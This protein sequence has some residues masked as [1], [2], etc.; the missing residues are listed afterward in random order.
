MNTTSVERKVQACPLSESHNIRRLLL[1]LAAAMPDGSQMITIRENSPI[2]TGDVSSP[3]LR[4][5]TPG[6]S[7][8]PR[9]FKGKIGLIFIIPPLEP[10]VARRVV[11]SWQKHLDQ[12]AM[13]VIPTVTQEARTL[14]DDLT[15]E[16]GNFIMERKIDDIAIMS[17]DPCTHYWI[18]NNGE[19]GTCKNCGRERNF[20]G[21]EKDTTQPWACKISVTIT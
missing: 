6:Q 11:W 3:L 12:R 18:I 15:G 7:V 10:V 17:P 5:F 14:M 16:Y 21:L 19:R 1:S 9:L 4:L 2:S 13:L 20:K 8:I